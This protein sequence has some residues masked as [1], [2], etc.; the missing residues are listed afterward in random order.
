MA[1][2]VDING[3]DI[4]R[5]CQ[6]I[7]WHPRWSRPA[8]VVVRYPG[9]LYSCGPGSELHLYNGG[10]LVFSGPVWQVQAEGGPNRT[11][12]EITAFDHLIYMTKRLCKQAPD[13]PQPYH[14]IDIWPTITDRVTAPAI[15]E[16]FVSAA[17][18]DPDASG[19]AP[20]PWSPGS[21]DGGPDVTSVPMNTPMSLD[22]MRQQL[23]ST[24]QLAINVVPGIGSST[25]N[26]IRPP[27]A[28]GSPVATFG[29]QT[30]SFN[31]QSATVTD[32][33]DEIINALWYFLG[34]RGPRA[35]IPINHWA[36]S[37]TPTAANAGGDG[38]GRKINGV[39]V[40]NPPRNLAAR[41]DLSLLRLARYLRVLPGG[42]DLR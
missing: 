32:D 36:G 5:F 16:A 40:D 15:M 23:L 19:S 28:V 13:G 33:M 39:F 9:H 2:T 6:S 22:T 26:F 17:I 8:T 20:L 21:I 38:K 41:N 4:T 29:Y 24:G 31:S 35:G 7:N 14:M 3:T 11:D 12:A 25:L 10:S 30:G 37:I 1:W 27:Q 18:S 42:Q 34:P